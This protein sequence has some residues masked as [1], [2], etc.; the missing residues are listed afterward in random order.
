MA[1][2]TIGVAFYGLRKDIKKGKFDNELQAVE[3][4]EITEFDP[5]AKIA[6]FMV[7]IGFVLDIVAMYVFKLTGGDRT[8]LGGTAH[9][10]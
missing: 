3:H 7:L 9:F 5:K 6:T 2:V 1:I 8:L 4:E 10:L